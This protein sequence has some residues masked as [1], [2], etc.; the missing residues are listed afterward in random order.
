MQG[1]VLV[2]CRNRRPVWATD[3]AVQHGQGPA[4]GISDDTILSRAHGLDRLGSVYAVGT[5]AERPFGS[6]QVGQQPDDR[7]PHFGSLKSRA[8]LRVETTGTRRARGESHT[9]VLVPLPYRLVELGSGPFP[10]LRCSVIGLYARQPERM[11]DIEHVAGVRARSSACPVRGPAPYR[12]PAAGRGWG[13]QTART[14][15]ASAG[16]SR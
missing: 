10:D 6:E 3:R 16:S 15:L 1:T 9:G 8:R 4:G 13:G 14:S 7:Q 12:P 5:V 11:S 2:E